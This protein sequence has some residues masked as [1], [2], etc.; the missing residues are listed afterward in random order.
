MRGDGDPTPDIVFPRGSSQNEGMKDAFILHTDGG[1]RGNP[2]PAAYAYVIERPGHPPI[3]EMVFMGSS[4]NNIAE[5]TGM[6]K[7]LEHSLELGA[8]HVIVHSDS[9]LMVKQMNGDYKVKNP[10]LLPLYQQATKLVREFETCKF[11][12]VYREQNT[13]ADRLCNEALDNPHDSP[14]RIPDLSKVKVETPPAKH[15][16]LNTKIHQHAVDLLEEFAEAWRQND[17]GAP[18]SADAWKELW[19]LLQKHHAVRE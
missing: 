15:Q 7:A 19:S 5:Y 3:E 2:G 1:S 4:T 13:H 16:E 6:L 11:K 8:R 14:P 10:G 18:T 17:P 12:H 9:E